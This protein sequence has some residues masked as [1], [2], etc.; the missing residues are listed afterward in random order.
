M[1]GRSAAYNYG[2]RMRR[3]FL[4]ILFVCFAFS[5]FAQSSPSPKKSAA[6]PAHTKPATAPAAVAAPAP[7]GPSLCVVSAIGH[8]FDVQTIGLTVFG[9][10]LVSVDTSSWG[11]DDLAVRKV[12]ALTGGHFAVRRLVLER[13]ALAAYEAPKKSIFQGGPLFRD[14]DKEFADML[15]TAAAAAPK[16]DFY[17]AITTTTSAL[18]DTNQYLAGIGIL[19]RGAGP[20]SLQFLFA[21]LDARLY[22]GRT[23]AL[24]TEKLVRSGPAIDLGEILTGPG[25]HGLYRRVDQSWLPNPPQT[26]AQNPRLRDAVWALIESGLA[27]TIPAVLPH[28]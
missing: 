21:I 28:S 16:C 23:F 5:A 25:I 10:A 24:Q 11:L 17:L 1:A 6:L 3:S 26:A 8:K 13:A 18:G 7:S 20:L 9:N 4:G 19:D 2:A 14:A 15:R 12:G 22:D 27:N